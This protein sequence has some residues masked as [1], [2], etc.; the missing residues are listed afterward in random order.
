M[1]TLYVF[2]YAIRVCVCVCMYSTHVCVCVYVFVT[3]VCVVLSCTCIRYTYMYTLY[4]HV[5]VHVVC[6]RV[7]GDTLLHQTLCVHM[8]MPYV[9]MYIYAHMYS[10]YT[11]VSAYVHSI[12]MCTCV[13]GHI[14]HQTLIHTGWR[15]LIGS[16]KLQIIFHKRA[17]RYRALLLK[18]TYKDK[19]SYESSPPCTIHVCQV[20]IPICIWGGYNK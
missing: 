14:S 17:T 13:C 5:Y 9:C 6:M 8:Y 19:G 4:M 20:Y 12:Y 2:V 11:G 3:H 15:R 18:M 16:P 10:I 1:Y 7:C